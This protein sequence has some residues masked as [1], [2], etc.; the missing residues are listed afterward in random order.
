M[1]SCFVSFD[2]ILMFFSLFSD[3]AAFFCFI[4]SSELES[5]SVLNSENRRRFVVGTFLVVYK[6]FPMCWV[7]LFTARRPDETTKRPAERR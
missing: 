1:N 4:C 6:S 5:Q 2:Y 7:S 3:S